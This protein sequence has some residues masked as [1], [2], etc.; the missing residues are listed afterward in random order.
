M[1]ESR[2]GSPGRCLLVWLLLSGGLA[3]AAAAQGPGNMP[4]APVRYAEAQRHELRGE[5]ILPG[6]VAAH[7]TSLVAS[8]V[9]G[10]VVELRAREGDTV[11]R[12]QTIARLRRQ[13]LELRLDEAQAQLKEAEARLDLAARSLE[14][15]RG[16][17]DSGVISQQQLDDAVSEAAA[18]EGRVEANKAEIARLEDDLSRTTITA[19]FDGAVVAEHVDVGEWVGVG[20]P[21]VEMV[22]LIDL[23]VVSAVPEQYFAAI[24]RGD[25]VRVTFEALPYLEL[26]GTVSAI[27]PRADARARTFPVK[28]RIQNPDLEVGV[29]MLARVAFPVGRPQPATI[30]PK[31]AL[32]GRRGEEAVFVI[33]DDDTVQRVPVTTGAA[34]GVWVAVESGVEP[35]Q[36]V[37]VRGNE[38]LRPGQKV[39]GEPLEYELP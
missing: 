34:S 30:V 9:E 5:A 22:S 36:K 25:T 7:T 18:W 37:V 13:N 39:S 3:V 29:G 16:L 26:E 1:S 35:G 11:R 27:V 19:P 12:G 14:R 31:D 24:Q 23:E 17:A 8:E 32:V 10:L 2:I 4:P 38:R 20:D 15:S 21:V 6:T 33:G 28:A